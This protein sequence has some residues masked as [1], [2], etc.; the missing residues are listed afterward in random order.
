M[1]KGNITNTRENNMT[2]LSVYELGFIN[3]TLY[4][5]KQGAGSKRHKKLRDR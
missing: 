2:D 1:L 3:N 5:V 4:F